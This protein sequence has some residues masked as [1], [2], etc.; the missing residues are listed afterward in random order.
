MDAAQPTEEGYYSAFGKERA[1]KFRAVPLRV[2]CN[3]ARAADGAT[4]T[5][6]TRNFPNRLGTGA[7]VPLLRSWWLRRFIGKLPTPE[8]PD[9]RGAGGG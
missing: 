6:S 2:W 9:P 1:S 5:T 7:N 8:V 3:R 4:S